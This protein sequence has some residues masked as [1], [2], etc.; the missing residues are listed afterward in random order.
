MLTHERERRKEKEG[1]KVTSSSLVGGV[2]KIREEG[3]EK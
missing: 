2:K 1:K 3:V